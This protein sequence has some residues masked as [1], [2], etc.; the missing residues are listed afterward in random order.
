M[1][2]I[3]VISNFLFNGF[4]GCARFSS[5]NLF[6]K[7]LTQPDVTCRPYENKSSSFGYF[8]SL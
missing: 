8:V 2:D 1:S 6:I 5:I 7:I 4:N 3:D